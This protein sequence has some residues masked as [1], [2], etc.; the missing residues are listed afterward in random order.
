MRWFYAK[1]V[2]GRGCAVSERRKGITSAEDWGKGSN[3]MWMRRN[4]ELLSTEESGKTLIEV[5]ISRPDDVQA[6]QLWK[7]TVDSRAV[8]GFLIACD[9]THSR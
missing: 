4:G 1:L 3:L 8:A 2:L 5:A 6:A 7:A 9:V